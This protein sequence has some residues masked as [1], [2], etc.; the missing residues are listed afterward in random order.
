MKGT[1]VLL[2][3]RQLQLG[4]RLGKGGEGEVYALESDP[5]AAVKIYTVKDRLSREAKVSAMVS[6]DLASRAKLVSFPQSVV[7]FGDGSFA[8]FVMRLVAGHKPLHELYSPGPRKQH[9][10]QA[11]Y[12]FLV[13]TATNIA[14]AVASVHHVG[15]VIGDINHSSILISPKATVA[16]IDADSF[17]FSPGASQFLCR[18]GVPEYTPPELQGSRLD[19]VVRTANHDAFGLAVVMFQL[20][21]MGRHPYVGAVR[22]GDIPPLHEAIR[23]YRYVYAED[24]DVGMDQPPGTPTISEFYPMLATSFDA[25]FS[26]ARSTT[27]PTAKSWVDILEGLESSLIKCLKNPLHY[28]P[29][30]IECVW[31]DMEE[32]LHT[33]LFLPFVPNAKLLEP[34]FDP[35]AAGFNLDRIWAQIQAVPVPKVD[36]PRRPEAGST[37]PSESARDGSG[38]VNTKRLLRLVAV[39]GALALLALAPGLWII[40]GPLFLWG[41]FA[42]DDKKVIDKE[43]FVRRYMAAGQAM[44]AALDSWRKRVGVDDLKAMLSDLQ[45]ARDQ[46]QTIGKE[47]LRLIQEY[48]ANRRNRQLFAYL[49]T[50]DVRHARIKGVGPAKEAALA[51][52]GIDTAADVVRE[53][54]L[55]VPGFGEV[56]SRGLF[57]W[58]SKLE[59]RFVYSQVP[60]DA[61]KREMARIRSVSQTR[62]AELRRLLSVGPR[63]V[64]SLANR[65]T[66][67]TEQVDP[68]VSRAA[69]ELDQAKCDLEFLKIPL[70]IVPRRASQPAG[71]QVGR[72]SSATSGPISPAQT[73]GHPSCPRCGSAM[74]RRLAR[75]GRHSG[76][77]FWGCARFP[78]C[79]GTRSI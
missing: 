78:T 49:D 73:G 14:R 13:R 21:C 6:A 1:R 8:G 22:R 72:A 62:A 66:V 55:S 18:V 27:R 2:N 46:Y 26:R 35:G 69:L 39:V 41:L 42:G 54:V 60:N 20:L 75:R 24:R 11:D 30:D 47:E 56:N 74:V 10:P 68:V 23:D 48:Q 38:G 57:E 12:R 77:A 33:V 50:F 45:T 40:C 3:D 28:I 59:K 9:F 71:G 70:P 16:L 5:S 4:T 52:Y 25:A 53:K 79:K 17:Q 43:C 44:E 19:S 31:C 63:N 7:R 34:T 76:N 51:S 37:V 15:C 32:A 36:V 67:A 64:A 58:R 61:D 65:V 29:R